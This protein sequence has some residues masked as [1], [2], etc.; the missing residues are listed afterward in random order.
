MQSLKKDLKEIWNLWKKI[1][2]G[3][4]AIIILGSAVVQFLLEETAPYFPF[5]LS[6]LEIIFVAAVYAGG[7]LYTVL[8]LKDVSK[9]SVLVFFFFILMGNILL[10]EVIAII[11]NYM[12]QLRW[13]V[14]HI[15]RYLGIYIL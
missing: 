7:I 8:K 3:A 10:L 11:G 9:F 13:E 2:L 15:L 14:D 12:Y 5:S 4:V 1:I 6:L